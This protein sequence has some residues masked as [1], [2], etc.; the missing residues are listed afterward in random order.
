MVHEVTDS[1]ATALRAGADLAELVTEHIRPDLL[2]GSVVLTN[3]FV[4]ELVVRYG[5]Q[6]GMGEERVLRIAQWAVGG[7][8]PD[9]TILVDGAGT[10]AAVPASVE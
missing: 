3:G 7:L 10:S 6:S 1:Q 4:D 8:R 9:L 5:V 2:A